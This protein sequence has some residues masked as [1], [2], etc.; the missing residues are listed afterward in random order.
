MLVDSH[1]H[2]EYEQFQADFAS[3]L[4]RAKE[5]SVMCMQTISTKVSQI[6]KIL[7]IANEYDFIYVSVGNHPNEIDNEGIIS[8]E[9]LFK[10]T[11]QPK[12]IGIGETGLDFHYSPAN[13]TKQIDSFINH[14]IVARKSNLPIIIHTRDA[15]IETI[16][17]LASQ[18][19]EGEFKG[20]IHCFSTSRELAYKA[21][22]LGL[23]I[24]LSGIITF[25]NAIEL[26][27]IVK[28]LPLDK[29]LIET[30]S[31]YLAPMPY[32]GKR[33]EPAYVKEVAMHLAGLKNVSFAEVAKI[34]TENF[35]KLFDKAKI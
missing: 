5:A 16:E 21:I 13:K 26:Q 12:I 3:M 29:L 1:C 7:A 8:V 18:M 25:K 6:D 33:N 9:E 27:N 19:K 35:F 17:V 28:D 4:Q 22:D 11:S 14:I 23:S 31:P 10:F 32:R 24:S 30:D 20:L 2:L 15:D 34:T